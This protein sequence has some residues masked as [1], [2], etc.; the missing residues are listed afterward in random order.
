MADVS[1]SAQVNRMADEGIKTLGKIDILVSN[2]AIR[3][4]RPIVEVTDEGFHQAMAT[5]LHLA[6]YLFRAVV[7]GMMERERGSIIA[8]GGQ[9]S[10]TGRPNTTWSLRRRRAYWD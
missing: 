3:P 10:I 7:P 9:S 1:D 5:N 8:M 4:H 6:F 2:V